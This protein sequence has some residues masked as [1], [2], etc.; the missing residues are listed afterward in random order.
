MFVCSVEWWSAVDKKLPT[1]DSPL[2]A[3]W[4][5]TLLQSA[6]DIR[7]RTRANSHLVIDAA[8]AVCLTGLVHRSEVKEV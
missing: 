8:Y 5:T 6:P 2:V 3:I 4:R 7:R 1:A